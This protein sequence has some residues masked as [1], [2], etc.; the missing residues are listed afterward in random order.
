MTCYNLFCQFTGQRM[1]CCILT[2]EHG[3]VVVLCTTIVLVPPL[4][5]RRHVVTR[6]GTYRT[7]GIAVDVAEAHCGR[8]WHALQLEAEYFQL[9]HHPRHTVGHHAEV[10]STYQHAC[11][12][13]QL[14]QFL[15]CLTIPELVVAMIVV[16]VVE[17]VERLLIVV[18]E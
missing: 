8:L 12:L 1:R 14:R 16:V 3:V 2:S 7:I 11:R 15:H 18:V 5:Q 17:A 9:V 10:F 6:Y 13:H 4:T